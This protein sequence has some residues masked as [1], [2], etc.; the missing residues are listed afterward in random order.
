MEVLLVGDPEKS[1]LKDLAE[2]LLQM[3]PPSA[4][5]PALTAHI[6]GPGDEYPS[7]SAIHVFFS[8]EG[9]PVSALEA[10]AR[11]SER[12]IVLPVVAR[13]EDA[14]TLPGSLCRLNAFIQE[15]FGDDHWLDALGEEIL[16]RLWLPRRER[17]VFIS[18]R[19]ADATRIAHQLFEAMQHLGFQVFLDTASIGVGED[20]QEQLWWWLT[21]ADLLILLASPRIGQSDWTRR[22][23]EYA[24]GAAVGMLQVRWPR[25]CYPTNNRGV[26]QRPDLG[27]EDVED[28]I[29]ELTLEDLRVQPQDRDDD[30]LPAR[31]LNDDEAYSAFPLDAPHTDLPHFLPR[32]RLREIIGR[33]LR[34]RVA[35]IQERRLDLVERLVA[36]EEL[37][38]RKVYRSGVGDLVSESAGGGG[39]L[40]R[41]VPC[42]PDPTILMDALTATKLHGEVRHG[43]LAYMEYNP[44]DR[45]AVA[46]REL[47]HR[48]E[49][50]GGVRFRVQTI[51][52]AEK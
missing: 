45:R 6:V 20:F 26:A 50:N 5:T 19:R 47:A 44:Q 46:L 2:R 9:L 49:P 25:E 51:S 3:R 32:S 33:A 38:G 10:A 7:C 37:A 13:V 28:R 41:V 1:P 27:V 15:V 40:I 36:Q 18:Y 52:G 31:A 4:D 24:K 34:I 21:D 42:R 12:H 35:A 29:I 16:A 30:A 22:E 23:V 8:H 48:D 39:E 14:R 43:R 17:R 11:D